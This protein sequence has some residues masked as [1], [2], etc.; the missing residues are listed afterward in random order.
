MSF[1]SDLIIGFHKYMLAVYFTFSIS[2]LLGFIV[3]RNIKILSV[4]SASLVSSLIFFIITNFAVWYASPF[5]SQ[6]I[7]G[8]MRCYILGLPFLNNGV[9]G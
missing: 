2:V 8:L 3:R 7:S 9:I 5:Y 1:L 6:D 4:F